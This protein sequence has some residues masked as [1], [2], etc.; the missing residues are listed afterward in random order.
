V[1][2]FHG[3]FKLSHYRLAPITESKCRVID[4]DI[5]DLEEDGKMPGKRF[6]ASRSFRSEGRQ[7]ATLAVILIVQAVRWIVGH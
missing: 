6:E 4:C 7:R 2:A 1:G 5:L 3:Y